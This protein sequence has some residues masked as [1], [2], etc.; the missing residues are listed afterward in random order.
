M[1]DTWMV[2][3]GTSVPSQRMRVSL[4]S[5]VAITNSSRTHATLRAIIATSGQP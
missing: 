2:I 1:A 4:Q 5:R 3:S